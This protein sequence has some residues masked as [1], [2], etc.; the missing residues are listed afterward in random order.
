MMLG[1]ELSLASKILGAVKTL[2]GL[3]ESLAAG[4]AQRRAAMAQKFLRVADCLDATA[5]ELRAGRY[6][7]GRCAEML[8]Y[9]VALP[10]LVRDEI[11]AGK[12]QE[13]GDVLLGAHEVESLHNRIHAPEAAADLARLDEAAG[14]LRALATLNSPQTEAK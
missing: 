14:L 5:S 2:C 10:P 1:A 3:R 9:A 13:V 8:E 12:S 4:T 6:P 7:H 11:G